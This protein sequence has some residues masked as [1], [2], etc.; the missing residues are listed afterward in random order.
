MN[1][2][3]D[4]APRKNAMLGALGI[5]GI[6]GSSFSD[7]ADRAGATPFY[8]YDR[9]ALKSNIA[10]IRAALPTE[11]EIYYSPKVNPF[12]PLVFEISRLVDG[13]D[14]ASS[15][16][17]RLALDC[18]VD[19]RQCLL[20]GPAKTE[21]EIRCGVGSGVTINI[22]SPEQLM[23]VSTEGLRSGKRPVVSIRVNSQFAVPRTSIQ[24]Y[25]N[26]QFG[27]DIDAAYQVARMAIERDLE[28][29]GFHLFFGS[30][31][32]DPAIIAENQL[33]AFRIARGLADAVG[34]SQY[35]V[36]VGG[37]FGVPF[38]QGDEELD[39]LEMGDRMNSWMNTELRTDR[40]ARIIIE[41]GRYIVATAGYYIMRVVD[42]K[43]VGEEQFLLVDGGLHHHLLASGTFAQSAARNAIMAPGV[44]TRGR[45]D[46]VVSVAGRLCSVMDRFATHVSLPEM[47]IGELVVIS[48]SGAYGPS[49][50]PSGFLSHDPAIE[51]LV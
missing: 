51:L 33:R 32:F 29:A 25:E 40:N 9:T 8:A 42:K 16:E 36:N 50:S 45:R 30:Q 31:Y 35:F 22:E 26:S 7:L 48:S 17:L 24:R 20:T 34:L 6:A 43:R 23:R 44:A 27:I 47:E 12:S 21:T 46:E 39:L 5:P 13:L 2:D 37:G 4:V 3:K 15:R 38:H 49:F 19:P 41:L 14:V 28:L 11:C 18:G 1:Q 10:S